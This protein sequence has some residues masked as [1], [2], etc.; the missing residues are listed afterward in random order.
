MLSLARGRFVHGKPIVYV[1]DD[2][3]LGIH[4]IQQY[5]A[6]KP[7]TELYNGVIENI[8]SADLVVVFSPFVRQVVQQFNPRVIELKANILQKYMDRSFAQQPQ[9][10]EPFR[11]GIINS[12]SRKEELVVSMAGQSGSSPPNI[13][14]KSDL[15]YGEACLPVFPGCNLRCRCSH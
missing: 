13:G 14:I 2:D 15:T 8:R 12:G 1:L 7:G 11:I 3:L 10:G 6:W 9:P 5:S 4:E